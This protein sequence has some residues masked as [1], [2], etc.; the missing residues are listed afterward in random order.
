MSN[1]KTQKAKI[2]F[3]YTTPYGVF[4]FACPLEGFKRNFLITSRIMYDDFLDGKQRYFQFQMQ[5]HTHVCL[6]GKLFTSEIMLSEIY[7]NY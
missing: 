3:G 4:V 6:Y 2:S 1:S 5:T 7:D